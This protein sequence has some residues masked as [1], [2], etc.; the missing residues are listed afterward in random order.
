MSSRSVRPL[1]VI[2]S[3]GFGRETVEAV[4]AVNAARPTWDLLGFLDD[5]PTLHRSEIDG[6]PVLGAIDDARTRF[7]G[8]ELV[9]CTGHPGNYSSRRKIVER[10]G[11][12][13][14]RYATVVHP[15]AVLP[16]TIEL[17][18]GTVLLAQVVATAAVRIGSH[19]AVMPGVVFTHD[20]IVEDF[21]TFGAGAQLAGRVHV[22]EGAYVGSGALV[23][24]DR[25]IGAW[26]LIGM[27]SIVT[28][29][30]PRGEVWVGTPAGFLRR[31][32]PPGHTSGA[33]VVPDSVGTSVTATNMCLG[34][35]RGN[36][37]T[38]A[39]WLA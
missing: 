33:G 1:V 35:G 4:R 24:E 16:T 37:R 2:G 17:G 29:D 6:V 23:R 38:S 14:I 13:A 11:L 27:G 7:E 21:A 5:D 32:D 30:I 15:A 18:V 39:C 8:A 36:P 12:P 28:R 22:E 25:T 20:D 31:A 9:V 34:E 10:L 19:V 3:G 26:S